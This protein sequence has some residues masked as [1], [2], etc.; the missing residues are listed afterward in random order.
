MRTNNSLEYLA[1]EMVTGALYHKSAMDYWS[2]GVLM[3]E[4]LLGVTPFTQTATATAATGTHSH[5]STGTM[6]LLLLLLL[7]QNH[8]HRLRVISML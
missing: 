5:A 8:C 6:T 7:V 4:L 2:L 3:H 1:P